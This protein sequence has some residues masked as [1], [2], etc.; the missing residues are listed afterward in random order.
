M[1]L[2]FMDGFDQYSEHSSMVDT[3]DFWYYVYSV[4]TITSPVRE[5]LGRSISMSSGGDRL[6]GGFPDQTTL[7]VGVAVYIWSRSTEHLIILSNPAYT[8]IQCSVYIGADYKLYVYSGS[9]GG[10]LIDTG[11]TVLSSYTWHYVEL[12]VV[13]GTSGSVQLW[14]NGNDEFSGA[15]TGN[16]DPQGTGVISEISL[17]LAG[18]DIFYD[19]FYLDDSTVHDQPKVITLYPDGD[20]TPMDWA[21]DGTGDDGSRFNDVN[22]AAY[23]D[24]SYIT[25][26]TVTDKAVFTY[27]NLP[28]GVWIIKG[29]QPMARVQNVL[30][31]SSTLKI[32][33]TANGTQTDTGLNVGAGSFK[34]VSGIHE[35]RNGTDA[36]T[37][38]DINAMTVTYEYET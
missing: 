37:E 30:G 26:S 6:V 38:T 22:E 5:G 29:V 33:T 34:Y 21:E 27:D 2:I 7:V 17:G 36:Y 35:T 12:K 32:T 8:D 14:V 9:S 23:D 31:G 4:T 3:S 20:S 18:N 1:A 11:T 16:T 25:S 24:T 15:T 19:D 28:T 13:V 10:T